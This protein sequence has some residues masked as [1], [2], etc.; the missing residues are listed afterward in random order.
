MVLAESIRRP[1]RPY[2]SGRY[3]DS[4]P[5]LPAHVADRLATNPSLSTRSAIIQVIGPNKGADLSRLQGKF[6]A[7]GRKR[8]RMRQIVRLP[9]ATAPHL[10]PPAHSPHMAQRPRSRGSCAFSIPD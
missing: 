8:T 4:D 7:S 6:K 1:G 10:R 2:G 9:S 5:I 3:R